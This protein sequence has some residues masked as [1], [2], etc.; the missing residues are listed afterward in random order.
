MHLELDY[1]QQAP[2]A[3]NY[4]KEC[5]ILELLFD[6]NEKAL[7]SFKRVLKDIMPP[8][9]YSGYKKEYKEIYKLDRGSLQSFY[10]E[11]SSWRF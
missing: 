2:I 3:I 1:E 10:N 5:V 8:G 7:K 4:L 6:R 11:Y 9:E